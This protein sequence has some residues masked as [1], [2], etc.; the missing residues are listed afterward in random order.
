M[1]NL[2][3]PHL[4]NDHSVLTQLKP[5]PCSASPSRPSTAHALSGRQVSGGS[6]CLWQFPQI[7]AAGPTPT[8]LPLANRKPNQTPSRSPQPPSQQTKSYRKHLEH[9]AAGRETL[10]PEE[11]RVFRITGVS[12]ELGEGCSCL[13]V[14]LWV[15]TSCWELMAELLKH[16]SLLYHTH[17]HTGKGSTL[18]STS[19]PGTRAKTLIKERLWGVLCLWP[20]PSFNS[21]LS[22]SQN[23]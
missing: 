15:P 22:L 14:L 18:S 6:C 21:L 1:G 2:W 20:S 16:M 10:C 5:L 8:L 12:Q 7:Q 4:W 23:V 3:T 19:F 13:T 17:T 11:E 9:R